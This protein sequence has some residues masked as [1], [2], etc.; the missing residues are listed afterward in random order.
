MNKTNLTFTLPVESNG[1][2]ISHPDSPEFI[3]GELIFFMDSYTEA[4]G[5]VERWLH[6]RFYFDP[7]CWDVEKHGYIYGNDKFIRELW[8]RLDARG[9]AV[10]HCINYSESGMQGDCYVDMDVRNDKELYLDLLQT[11]TSV[12]NEWPEQA[13]TKELVA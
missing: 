13:K 2:W 6:C 8:G 10:P 12:C 3:T 7:K 4:S 5:E 11:G 1:P 9:W